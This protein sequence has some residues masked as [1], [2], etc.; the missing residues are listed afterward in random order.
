MELI[1][2]NPQCRWIGIDFFSTRTLQ[3]S[4]C[5]HKDSFF[6][7]WQL[8]KHLHIGEHRFGVGQAG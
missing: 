2:P 8:F 3:T 6:R 5:F 7:L 4:V 1:V